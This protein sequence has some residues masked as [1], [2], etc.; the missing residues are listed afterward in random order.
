MTRQ[1]TSGASFIEWLEA[2]GVIPEGVIEVTIKAK[3][4]EAVQFSVEYWAHELGRVMMD[5]KTVKPE[6]ENSKEVMSLTEAYKQYKCSP[7]LIARCP[8]CQQVFIDD[9]IWFASLRCPNPGC[10]GWA[11][12]REV[13]DLDD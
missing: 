1:I 9:V 12:H 13:R 3:W 4:G 6:S 5:S 8:N 7:G 2:A 11:L 10:E